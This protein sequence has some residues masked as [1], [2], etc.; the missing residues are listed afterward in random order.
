MASKMATKG[1][2]TILLIIVQIKV[3]YILNETSK[4]PVN[5]TQFSIYEGWYPG[6]GVVLDCIDS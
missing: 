4:L 5:K 1:N 3:L 2:V 6:S